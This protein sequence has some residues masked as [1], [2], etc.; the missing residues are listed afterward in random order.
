MAA[1][2]RPSLS[3]AL[4]RLGLLKYGLGLLLAASAV[5]LTVGAYL[6]EGLGRPKPRPLVPPLPVAAVPASP[7]PAAP[8]HAMRAPV[9]RDVRFSGEAEPPAGFAFYDITDRDT[10]ESLAAKLGR[11]Q[12]RVGRIRGEQCNFAFPLADPG[13]APGPVAAF[14]RERGR[15]CCAVFE[16]VPDQ[17]A[18]FAFGQKRGQ[19]PA[20]TGPISGTAVFSRMGAGLL[21]LNLRF[22][23]Q[24]EGYGAAVARHLTS[25][26][27]PPRP[28][29]QGG[30]AWSRD[31]GLVI[32]ARDG[33]SLAV[34]AYFV[35]NIDRHA[36]L[37]LARGE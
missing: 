6:A 23:D 12:F 5:A 14:I 20:L 4:E 22:S 7:V 16:T 10:P 33:R 37:A 15:Q 28:L 26:F 8:N 21:T 17:L 30:A 19:G 29:P 13:H 35:A 24:A 9:S 18:T 25:R 3:M 2:K 34:T 32:L 27:G 36:A 11:K 1:R 31:M